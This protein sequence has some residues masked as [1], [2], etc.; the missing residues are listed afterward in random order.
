MADQRASD[1]YTVM[2]TSVEGEKDHEDEIKQVD[3]GKD[4][5]ELKKKGKL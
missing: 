1:S 3:Q 2:K 4:D 5:Q